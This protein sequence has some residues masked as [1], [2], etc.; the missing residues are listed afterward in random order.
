MK[1][2]DAHAIFLITS[3]KKMINKYVP[4]FNII[5]FV[6]IPSY[7]ELLCRNYAPEN[8]KNLISFCTANK[9]NENILD[10]C[11]SRQL[12]WKLFQI[13]RTF[14]LHN[15]K[16]FLS[17]VEKGTISEGFNFFCLHKIKSFLL[18]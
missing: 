13:A 7:I 14:S 15:Q 10:A 9:G 8:V 18:K 11:A 2:H 5:N 12:Q 3:G 16:F 6:V 17:S 4:C 1:K